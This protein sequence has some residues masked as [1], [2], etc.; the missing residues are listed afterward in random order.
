M[1]LSN[2]T[3]SDLLKALNSGEGAD[4]VRET[5]RMVMLFDRKHLGQS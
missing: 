4:L 3:V 5:V 2:S 1:T